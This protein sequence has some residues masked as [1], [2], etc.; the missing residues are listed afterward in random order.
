MLS[1]VIAIV[2]V[3]LVVLL[4]MW[5]SLR[6]FELSAGPG[7]AILSINGEL[8]E[9]ETILQDLHELTANPDTKALVVRINTPGGDIT[10]TEELYKAIRRVRE[11]G[12]PV[13]ASM[14][15]A[16]TSG[17]YYVSCA[18]QRIFANGSSLT[19][20]LGV[21]IE[22]PNAETLL[23]KIGLT[24]ETVASG[25]FKDT[26]SFAHTMTD[27]QRE[28]LNQLVQDFHSQ[29]VALVS[30]SRA[31]T[32]D[33]VRGLSDGR[34]F[35]GRQACELGLVDELG[36]QEAA[37]RYAAGLGGIADTEPRIIRVKERPLSW[38]S[39]LDELDMLTSHMQQEGLT[40]RFAVR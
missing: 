25:E 23:Q 1:A 10:V 37:V 2:S 12:I 19:G 30:E 18:A 15:S 34:V 5:F 7:V 24:F 13:V 6:A 11:E 29:F 33:Q 39:M 20:G 4:S 36:D 3:V 31:L 40:P 26:G 16:A 14:G 8:M 38:R 21:I 28:H 22:Y 9:Q 27:R 32:L 35:S 17:G